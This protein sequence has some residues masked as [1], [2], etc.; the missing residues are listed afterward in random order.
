MSSNFLLWIRIQKF[1]W[2]WSGLRKN[3][4]SRSGLNQSGST[5]LVKIYGYLYRT[6]KNH[7]DTRLGSVPL[8]ARIS[9]CL[10]SCSCRLNW[11]NS[12]LLRSKLWILLYKK[13]YRQL[14]NTVELIQLLIVSL[15]TLD[16]S[17]HKQKLP[18]TLEYP[19]N[20][21][22]TWLL[23]SKLWIL[24]YTQKIPATLPCCADCWNRL[25]HIVT[26]KKSTYV[27]HQILSRSRQQRS[28][29]A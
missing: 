6:I 3:A 11:S 17:L 1:C 15:Q 5:T 25:L 10:S 13:K 28:Q 29:N 20:W 8:L 14:C 2:S 7:E 19:L 4:G 22:N 9:S 21:S 24:L 16:T 27:E 18:A 26:K 23:R 12:W